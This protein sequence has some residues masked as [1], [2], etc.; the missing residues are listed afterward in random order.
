[1]R[2]VF[3]FLSGKFLI[4]SFQ[5]KFNFTFRPPRKICRNITLGKFYYLAYSITKT[6]DFWPCTQFSNNKRNDGPLF[7]FLL[8]RRFNIYNFVRF[9]INA[10]LGFYNSLYTLLYRFTISN[11]VVA[12]IEKSIRIFFSVEWCFMPWDA[13]PPQRNIFSVPL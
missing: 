6:S 13:L 11:Q 10:C 1:M 2:W 4:K 5:K 8:H 9:Y 3:V 7:V 12:K